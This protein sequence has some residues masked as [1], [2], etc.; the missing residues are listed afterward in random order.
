MFKKF[1]LVA[2]VSLGG[3]VVYPHQGVHRYVTIHPDYRPCQP[4][5]NYEARQ[6]C[7]RGAEA[8]A[9]Q[10]QSRLNNQAYQQGFGGRNY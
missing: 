2:V 4:I 5:W 8:R 10:E 3:C 1:L 7:Y 9:R 6:N